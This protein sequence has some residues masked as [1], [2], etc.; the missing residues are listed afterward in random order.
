MA[1]FTEDTPFEVFMDAKAP[2][3]M[4]VV[5]GR[6]DLFAVFDNLSTYP[7]RMQFNGQTRTGAITSP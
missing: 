2:T 4:Q 6:P 3:P 5:H 1:L 7:V